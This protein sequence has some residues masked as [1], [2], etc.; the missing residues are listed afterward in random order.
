[1]AI[2]ADVKS[3][4]FQPATAGGELIRLESPP[5]S[6]GSSSSSSSDSEKLSPGSTNGRAWTAE[7]HNRFL[8]GLEMFPSGP[9]KEIAAHVGSRTTRQTMTHAQKYREKIARRKR[10]LRS[11]A[12]TEPRSLKRRRD[13]KQQHKRDAASPCSLKRRRD[14]KQ[15]H[16]RDAASPCSVAAPFAPVSARRG[17]DPMDFHGCFMPAPIVTLPSQCQQQFY[18]YSFN[19]V[20]QE[21]ELSNFAAMLCDL[22]PLPMSEEEIDLILEAAMVPAPVH[23]TG[24]VL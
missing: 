6:P 8:E 16:K 19:P 23:H 15:Q 21:A 18:P 12:K 14:H 7:E 2:T 4:L 11:S 3:Q 17:V 22:D 1:M 13:H 5:P 10:G 20:G 24:L 9:W